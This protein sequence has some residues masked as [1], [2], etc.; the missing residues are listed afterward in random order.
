M[1]IR[2]YRAYLHA[3]LGA[4]TNGKVFGDEYLEGYYA[5]GFDDDE[6]AD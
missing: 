6:S 4:S 3:N 2:R 5:S 1:N